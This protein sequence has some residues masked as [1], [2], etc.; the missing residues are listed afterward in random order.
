MRFIS[1]L[2]RDT[3][4]AFALAGAE[5]HGYLLSS[6]RIT[7][8]ALEDAAVVRGLGLPLFADNGTKELIDEVTD[9]GGG[10]RRTRPAR[11]RRR[12]AVPQPLHPGIPG[13]LRTPPGGRA[14]LVAE[15]RQTADW[16]RPARRALL[17]V[18]SG[19][20][21][22]L[23]LFC[24]ADPSVRPIARDTRIAHMNAIGGLP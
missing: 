2:R 23:P 6:H 21:A 1:N 20:T 3:I 7:P 8:A 22:A 15:E 14:A 16:P 24:E 17:A 11:R 13:L 18:P 5:S 9:P 19:L 10:C 12:L 4:E